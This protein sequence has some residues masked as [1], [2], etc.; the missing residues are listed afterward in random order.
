MQLDG[1][2]VGRQA[3]IGLEE[4]D[5]VGVGGEPRPGVVGIRVGTTTASRVGASR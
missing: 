2:A 4:R 1:K 5:D 3:D